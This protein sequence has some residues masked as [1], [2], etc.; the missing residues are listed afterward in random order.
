MDFR[1][2]RL[3]LIDSYC[4]NRIAELDL[5][6]HITINGENAVGKTTLLRLLPIFFGESP[7]KIVR[8]DA[9]TE[10]FSRY[11]FPTTSSYVIF[12]Y[13]RRDEYAMAVVHADGQ[14][15]S[16]AYRFVDRPY[17]LDLFKD[18]DGIVQTAHLFRH[19]S[20]HNV[21]QSP[22]LPLHVYRD[23][24]QNTAS[25]EHRKLAARFAFTSS[26]GRLAHI[27]RVV[28]GILHRAMT[29]H[30]LKRMVV[31]SVMGDNEQISLKVSRRAITDWI[32]EH[33]SHLAMIGKV[34]TMEELEQ[35]DHERR[36]IEAQVSIIHARFRL[37]VDF[38]RAK[39][40]AVEALEHTAQTD[41]EATSREF[42]TKVRESADAM[43][44]L[45]SAV[46][47]AKNDLEGLERRKREYER[48]DAEGKCGMVDG[49]SAKLIELASLK[50]QLEQ[51]EAKV[52]SF[53]EVFDASEREA[54]E[55]ASA[56]AAEVASEKSAAAISS[57][58]ARER[59][60]EEHA[61]AQNQRREAQ[62]LELE[63]LVAQVE[64]LRVEESNWVAEVKHA[65]PDSGLLEAI[66]Q[67]RE[68][69]RI[70]IGLLDEHHETEKRLQANL[71]REQVAFGEL[72]DIIATSEDA[73]DKLEND[74]RSLQM[75]Q[76]ASEDTLLGFLRLN[77]PDWPDTIGCLVT[78]DL[79]LRT[80][81]APVLENGDNLYGVSLDLSSVNSGRFASEVTLREEIKAI[82]ARISARTDALEKDKAARQVK[83]D[84][85]DR[86]KKLLDDLT[87]TISVA[88]ARRATANQHL[89]SLER[90]VESSRR[91]A[92]EKADI[93]LKGCRFRLGEASTALA[94]MR[95][96]HAEALRLAETT[97][98][99]AQAELKQT[100][101]NTEAAL[102]ARLRDSR[103]NLSASLAKIAESRSECLQANGVAPD[104]VMKLRDKIKEVE[105]TI[106]QAENQRGY[107]LQYRSWME[108]QWSQYG[109]ETE[110][111]AIRLRE[112]ASLKERHALLLKQR[113]ATLNEKNEALEKLGADAKA[114]FALQRRSEG[115]VRELENY[116]PADPEALKGKFDET[117]SVDLL[118]MER[119][120]LLDEIKA[121]REVIRK[122]T[123]DIRREMM[124]H[125][126]SGPEKFLRNFLQDNQIPNIGHEYQWITVF[127]SWFTSGMADHRASLISMG[128]M[129]A[130]E[131][132]TFWTSLDNLK[133]S[134]AYFSRELSGHLAQG[135]IFDSLT[136]VSVD[137][138]T[139][140]D[141]Q[142]YKG[143]VENLHAEY[144]E[145]HAQG[146]AL[147]PTS[148]LTA[149]KAV[150]AVL[151]NDKGLVADPVDL[152]KLK[153][154]ANV[155]NQGIKTA[156]NERELTTMSSN[157]LSYIIL[158]VIL[159]GFV[160]RIRNKE[161]V[162]I[163]FV[164]DELRDL[165]FQN[166]KTMIEL[167]GRN[168]IC[169]ISAFPDVDLDL[170]ELFGKNY[171]ILPGRK[172]GL[173][174]LKRDEDALTV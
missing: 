60:L 58:A 54:K 13:R 93:K 131:I 40:I 116:W 144:D 47:Q 55:L 166:A 35:K 76:N 171:K 3:I 107:V 160:N 115:E 100:L 61:A 82:E 72:D 86:A 111:Q 142:N 73:I 103:K 71:R 110:R 1:I 33:E 4:R 165:S 30:D 56:V 22:P 172:V 126:G 69:Q 118:V 158:C 16:V 113:E 52:K 26:T 65:Q 41:I 140:L 128:R 104:V 141:T 120:R 17:S 168:N 134:V 114:Y 66:R 117:F 108:T 89:A 62:A 102:D 136:D 169:M 88:K 161:Q 121:I 173:I 15:D 70:S 90:R 7:S 148:F 38:Y 91:E 53:T 139:Q 157:G 44:T 48:N 154:S 112:F 133:R 18:Q 21:T 170:A 124:A 106:Q 57:L 122:G 6:D 98:A 43:S 174:N 79:L 130:Q 138:E 10:R 151:D 147:P 37:A 11:Y 67:A 5:T 81:L 77:K 51:L 2:T 34:A 94:N 164:I 28:T 39:L 152:I 127:R 64:G 14:S 31:S 145:W 12:E 125:V 99:S 143:A 19:L 95:T 75:A 78:E 162:V 24:I 132:S 119:R 109:V 59:L 42:A 68:E 32:G 49:L 9:V 97:L 46:R 149:L 87:A 156:S 137:I 167:L 153:V 80:D 8:G 101:I 123:E 92:A 159:I 150:E 85:R 135:R 50:K 84:D 63:P 163:P 155:N 25:R 29:F 96:A 83:R 27:E 146:E 105:E 129:H 20:K 74:K 36:A 23:V 45:D